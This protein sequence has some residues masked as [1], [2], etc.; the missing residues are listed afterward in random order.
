MYRHVERRLAIV[1]RSLITATPKITDQ[2]AMS[3]YEIDNRAVTSSSKLAGV[4]GEASADK[5]DG[6]GNDLDRFIFDDDVI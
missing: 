6:D 5:D 3:P 1:L 2:P 4:D